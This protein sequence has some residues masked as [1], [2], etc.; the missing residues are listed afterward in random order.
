MFKTTLVTQQ[1]QKQ[2]IDI[3]ESCVKENNQLE[4]KK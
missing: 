4:I 1:Q 2:L 3:V